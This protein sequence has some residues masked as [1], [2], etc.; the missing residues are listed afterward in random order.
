M[1]A[2]MNESEIF[3]NGHELGIITETANEA[4]IYA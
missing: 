2:K 3:V 1:G 4:G